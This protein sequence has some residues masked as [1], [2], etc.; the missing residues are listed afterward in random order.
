MPPPSRRDATPTLAVFARDHYWPEA[1]RTLSPSTVYCYQSHWKHV[2]AQMGAIPLDRITEE[3][4]RAFVAGYPGKRPERPLAPL[5]ACLALA[6]KRGLLG[7]NPVVAAGVF[8]GPA[9]SRWVPAGQQLEDDDGEPVHH[10]L[11]EMERILAAWPHAHPAEGMAVRLA[12]KC[13]LRLG[14]IRALRP[15]DV[16]LRFSWNKQQARYTAGSA[17]PDCY[18]RGWLSVQQNLVRGP[19][20]WVVK[21]PK[22]GKS[23]LV[24]VP[25]SLAWALL[26]FL[27]AA[28]PGRT[29][30]E[31]GGV[32]LDGAGSRSPL[33]KVLRAVQVELGLDP[34][35]FHDLRNTCFSSWL[36][37]GV[38]PWNASFWGG[39][40]EGAHL[41]KVTRNHYSGQ[42]EIDWE[43]AG[44]MEA[45]LASTPKGRRARFELVQ[46]SRAS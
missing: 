38:K 4:V 32:P 6:M 44:K 41:A 14:E 8:D 40:A 17:R 25:E 2:E 12:M 10:S 43:D 28:S 23:R 5:S 11:D 1:K 20:G 18:V 21:R 34:H 31:R 36:A 3:D 46:P 13:C 22:S 16:H 15:E 42:P 27:D 35:G 37:N 33:Q 19:G 7:S 39:H 24:P 26:P 9:K 29:L 30:L 45:H